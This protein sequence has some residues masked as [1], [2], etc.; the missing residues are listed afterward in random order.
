MEEFRRILAGAGIS[1]LT[2]D[3]FPGCP[4]VI[5]DLDTF[6]GNAVKKA[7]TVSQYAGM[8]AV[9]DDSGLEVYALG[10]APGVRSARY[11]GNG[12]SDS[13]NTDK[14]L[15]DLKNTPESERGARFVC[16]LALA[17]PDGRVETFEGIVEGELS[18]I[19]EGT[20]GFGYDP[21][22]RP[23]GFDRTFGGMSACEKDS[24][25]HRRMA[26]DKLD[27]YLKNKENYSR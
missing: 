6:E 17:F 19:P 4:E 24:L 18:G 3:D 26:L 7:V 8:P 23:K 13:E 5:E 14:L 10:G 16:V 2:P 20:G 1:M 9:S 22:F 27:A 21:I 15:A 25:S 11:A 12:S